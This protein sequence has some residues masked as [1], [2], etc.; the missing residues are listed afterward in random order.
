MCVCVCVYVQARAHVLSHFSHVLLFVILWTIAHQASRSMGFSRKKYWS[1]LPC[2]PPGDLPNPG[3]E[4]TSLMASPA[5]A[6][7][8]GWGWFF[9]ISATWEALYVVC[10]GESLPLSL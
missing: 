9:A 4:P 1:G 3:I 8:G 10:V 6:G 2:S 5:L 7:G